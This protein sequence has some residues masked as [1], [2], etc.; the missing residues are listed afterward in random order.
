[1]RASLNI[2]KASQCA[3][4]IENHHVLLFYF[5]KL[6]HCY[7]FCGHT[8]V[9]D[10]GQQL[11]WPFLSL[12]L[13]ASSPA[14]C[15]TPIP[16]ILTANHSYC[17]LSLTSCSVYPS[18]NSTA[19]PHKNPEMDLA[20]GGHCKADAAA[21]EGET[22]AHITSLEMVSKEIKIVKTRLFG[23]SRQVTQRQW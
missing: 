18:L 13:R 3:A 5:L 23:Q 4:R 1:M 11:R 22:R 20:G 2:F 8:N 7:F 16:D 14:S 12:S 9:L 17:S 15:S 21:R 6:K 19:A 10:I